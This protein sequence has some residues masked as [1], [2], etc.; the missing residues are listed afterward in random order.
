[1]E[2]TETL[3][4]VRAKCEI[5]TRTYVVESAG[6]VPVDMEMTELPEEY[7]ASVSDSDED[8]E[9]DSEEDDEMDIDEEDEEDEEK[10]EQTAASAPEIRFKP[11]S[12][13][14]RYAQEASVPAF[15][16]AEREI[17]PQR[18]QNQKK[19]M[20]QLKKEGR[21]AMKTGGEYDFND[22]FG[23]DEE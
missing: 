7:A 22:H 8:M 20:K 5:P 1:M 15:T 23:M 11:I 9:V 18:N 17:N 21:R 14:Q 12:K 6:S 19:I 3:E 2:D 13:K 10:V 4:S 16:A